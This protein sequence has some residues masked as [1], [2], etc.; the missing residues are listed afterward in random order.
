VENP[1]TRNVLAI[2]LD[3]VFC[4]VVLGTLE[5]LKKFFIYAKTFLGTLE[6]S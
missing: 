4:P 5:R 2:F 1:E 3:F 6:K